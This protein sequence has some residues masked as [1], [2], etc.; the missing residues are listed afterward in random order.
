M[1]SKSIEFLRQ[2]L[3]DWVPLF[4][5]AW[6]REYSSQPNI[7]MEVGETRRTSAEQSAKFD[8]GRTPDSIAKGEKPITWTLRSPHLEGEDRAVDFNIYV[9]DNV[10]SRWVYV[11][12][13]TD[14]E[15]MLYRRAA[16]IGLEVARAHGWTQIQNGIKPDH[17]DPLKDRKELDWPHWQIPPEA[18]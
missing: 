15:M 8:I 5:A 18:K 13:N 1:P 9:R 11:D 16:A 14:A 6:H 10:R 17:G 3:R 2:P 12:G 7:K 4:L